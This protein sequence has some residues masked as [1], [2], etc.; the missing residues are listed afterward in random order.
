MALALGA[1]IVVSAVL[2]LVYGSLC[3][4]SG[5]MEAEFERFGLARFRRA[6][7]G[8]EV[9]GGLGLLIGL[10]VPEVLV[11]ASAGL[12]LLMLLG[13]VARL[14]VRDAFLETLPAAG[15]LVV[16]VVILVEAWALVATA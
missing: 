15:L 16:N 6:T 13:L 1:A 4:V 3:L 12:A 8:L 2:F 14:R 11:I 10:V 5:G 9:V 7:G